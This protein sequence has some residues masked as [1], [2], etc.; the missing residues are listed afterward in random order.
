MKKTLLLLAAVILGAMMVSC[1]K[2]K[3]DEPDAIDMG[4]SVKWASCNLGASDPLEYGDYYSWGDIKTKE[5]Y[6]D[7]PPDY[8]YSANP[9]NLTTAKRDPAKKKLGGKWRMPTKEEIAELVD[10]ANCK[11]EK[12]TNEDGIYCVITSLKTNNSI[13]LPAASLKVEEGVPVEPGVF[14]VYWSSNPY[15]GEGGINGAAYALYFGVDDDTNKFT[16]ILSN[17][18]RFMGIPIRPV[19][20]N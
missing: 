6:G 8:T 19:C 12:K 14:G 16:C 20:K 3:A 18:D 4:L 7:A 13:T 1:E 2:D 15:P 9:D 17:A 10:P 5:T 11:I